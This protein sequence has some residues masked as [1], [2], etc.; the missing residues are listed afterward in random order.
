[1]TVD[2]STERQADNVSNL[3]KFSA[4]KVPTSGGPW[5]MASCAQQAF[6]MP[7]LANLNTRFHK[8][9]G[10]RLRK[11]E[12]FIPFIA[13]KCAVKSNDA[14]KNGTLKHFEQLERRLRSLHNLALGNG[15]TEIRRQSFHY[16]FGFIHEF[17][18]WRRAQR[19]AHQSLWAEKAREVIEKVRRPCC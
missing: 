11:I 16:K 10:E 13:L 5:L 12:K 14:T 3:A 2:Q 9:T 1:L 7:T 4:E 17:V 19:S 15:L 6:K 8:L 18:S